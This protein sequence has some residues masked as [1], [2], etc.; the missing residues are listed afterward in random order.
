MTRAEA[1]AIATRN[2]GQG[3]GYTAGFDREKWIQQA[4]LNP[5]SSAD[6]G[7]AAPPAAAAAPQSPAMSALM[8]GG[9]TDDLSA[10]WAP[11]GTSQLNPNLG[12]VPPPQRASM[13][14]LT[15]GY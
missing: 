5:S 6:T 1:E 11:V 8:G 14:A 3:G 12:K 15:A 10:G 9:A 2:E 7:A 13:R 4:M